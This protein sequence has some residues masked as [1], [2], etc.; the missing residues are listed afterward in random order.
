[1]FKAKNSKHLVFLVFIILLVLLSQTTS[2]EAKSTNLTD[3]IMPNILE[4]VESCYSEIN[5]IKPAGN[6]FNDIQ[7]A[8]IFDAREGDTII[9]DKPLYISTGDMIYLDK[10]V[11]IVGKEGMTPILDGKGLSRI[12]YIQENG[13]NVVI[14]NCEFR[15]GL[16]AQNGG[17]AILIS[18]HDIEISD[19][20]FRNNEAKGGGAI[21]TD[22][23]MDPNAIAGN[24]LKIINCKFYNNL[25]TI[26]AG[27][28]GLYGHNTELI[29]CIFNSNKVY[30]KYK[31]PENVFGGA[32]QLGKSTCY[33]N[34]KCLMCSFINNSAISTVEG[35]QSHGGAGCLREGIGYIDCVFIGNKAD[36]G[37]ALNYHSSG[38]V[39]RCIF[40]NNTALNSYG[41]ALSCIM[42]TP[43]MNL[44]IKD[45]IFKGNIAPMGGACY[46]RGE[47]V[48]FTNCVLENNHA[49]KEG[50]AIFIRSESTDIYNCTF[51][52]NIANVNGGALYIDANAVVIQESKF[53]NNE[54]IPDVKKINDGLGG[55]IYINSSESIISSNSFRYNTA[56]NGSAIYIDR[57][58]TST[59]INNNEM[60]ENQAWVYKLPIYVPI[61]PVIYGEKVDIKS[62]IYGGN[63]IGNASNIAI[64]NAIYNNALTQS[65]AIDG[66]RPLVGATSSGQL[67]QDDKEFNTKILLT[68]IHQDGTLVYNNTLYSNVY[69]EVK[70]VLRDLKVGKYEVS[71]THFEDNY[72]KEITNKTTFTVIPKA[73]VEFTKIKPVSDYYYKDYIVWNLTIKNNGPNKAT[74]LTIKDILPE[75]LIW[76]S[77]NSDGKYN[78]TTG[79]LSLSQLDISQSM[80]LLIVTQINKTGKIIN[81]G[82]VSALE[83]DPDL[84]NNYDSD[85]IIVNNSVDVAIKQNVSQKNPNVDSNVVWTIIVTNNGPDN[86]TLVKVNDILPEGLIWISDDSEGKYNPITGIWYLNKLNKGET[87]T[88]KIISKVKKSGRLINNA[89]ITCKEYDWNMTNNNA[90]EFIDVSKAADLE[91]IKAVNNSN[92]NY[93]ENIK[94]TI[95][96]KNNGP[97]DAT[98]VVLTEFMPDG[99]IIINHN[100]GANFNGQIWNIDKLNYGESKELVIYCKINKTGTFINKVNVVGNEYDQN[101]NNNNYSI[102]INVDSACDLEVKK[103]SFKLEYLPNELIEY[104]VNV[105]NDGPDM[106]HN[107]VLYDILDKDASFV[108]FDAD[109]GMFNSD[110]S[111]WSIDSL[112]SGQQATLTFKATAKK[113]GNIL[114]KVSV[115]CDEEDYNPFNNIDE[116]A[117]SIE[118][119][120]EKLKSKETNISKSPILIVKAG[121]YVKE[122]EK[123]GSPI[124]ILIVG[125]VILVSFSYNYFKKN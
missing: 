37:G 38:N 1:M 15:N 41:G 97:D 35:Y 106:A 64:S 28:V 72:Y 67:Y 42:Y 33:T 73:D 66:T 80:T 102:T 110:G 115:S 54:A 83:Y 57:I 46:L 94:W 56:R 62:I 75:G 65:L 18:G 78:P 30:N 9:L 27:A 117:V 29:N 122:L 36:F 40:E 13:V 19:C 107:V 14:K 7:N 47:N 92:P 52:N 63:N 22:Y 44:H 108:A 50:G 88:L 5:E 59:I 93:L 113:V 61:T 53:N 109:R 77:D 11:N 21:Y 104:V 84:S 89:S 12:L 26:A 120:I 96:V 86:A 8:I 100:G 6:T 25:A 123:T 74:E 103:T 71:A 45:S 48:I 23:D 34:S 70:T 99:I 69:G 118:S 60:L 85:F 32:V 87:R 49:I 114:N 39:E 68:I 2:C 55:A 20:I 91:V 125:L 51:N 101:K 105:I 43:T 116:L 58:A 31:S 112:D 17:G 10:S 95:A 98:G 16:M 76:I 81:H 24:N 4:N 90:F 3:D 82:N 111:M 121:K 119:A 79:I 124:T